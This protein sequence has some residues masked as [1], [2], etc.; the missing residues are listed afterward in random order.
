[1]FLSASTTV[2]VVFDV[3]KSLTFLA[4]V[5]DGCTAAIRIL[6][7]KR[8]G[9]VLFGKM[10]SAL[11]SLFELLLLSTRVSALLLIAS[12]LTFN[13]VD[14]VLASTFLFSSLVG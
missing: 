6:V 12:L 1:M 10:I 11:F 7:F 3:I 13:V 5:D 14:S 8:L 4:S 9:A 2:N